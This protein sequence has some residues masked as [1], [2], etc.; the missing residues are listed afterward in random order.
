[1]FTAML[2]SFFF[3]M[4]FVSWCAQG[5]TV[6]ADHVNQVGRGRYVA[7]EDFKFDSNIEFSQPDY[8]FEAN[9]PEGF[10]RATAAE[11]GVTG[12]HFWNEY[13][14]QGAALVKI[15]PDTVLIYDTVTRIPLYVVGCYRNGKAGG[16]NRIKG[17]NRIRAVPPRDAQPKPPHVDKPPII[18]WPPE[19][20]PIVLK[21]LPP[22][23]PPPPEGQVIVLVYDP[24]SK[25]WIWKY[26]PLWCVDIHRPR[27]LWHPAACAALALGGY[28]LAG[29]FSGAL[30]L[31]PAIPVIQL[32]PFG[33]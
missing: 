27:D 31:K 10:G 14:G 5:Q 1:M 22:L 30:E 29:G 11:L 25:S 20:P 26:T 7:D 28:A 16:L 12:W 19:L 2:K 18:Y 24:P 13:P 17:M 3:A 8:K 23:P 21:D 6:T 4:V 9:L 32:N 33:L 15:A